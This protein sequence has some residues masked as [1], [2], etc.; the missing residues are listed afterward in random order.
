[1]PWEL[2]CKNSSKSSASKP[3][4]CAFAPGQIFYDAIHEFGA[5]GGAVVLRL[6]TNAGI[7]GWATS[8]F[9]TMEGGPLVLQSILQNQVKQ[10]PVGQ[11]P[12]FPKRLRSDL[13]KA[14]EY[15]TVQWSHCGCGEVTSR[16]PWWWAGGYADASCHAQRDLHGGWQLQESLLDDRDAANVDS[17]VLAPQNPGMGSDLRP[18]YVQK[19]KV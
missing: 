7:T 4:S 8:S 12:A 3:T 14:L 19:H 1:L 9:G 2:T 5:A 17:A 18:E 11:D 10:V 6:Q 16:Q 15:S 13:W